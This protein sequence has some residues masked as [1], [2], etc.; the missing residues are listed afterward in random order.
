MC[1]CHVQVPVWEQRS[2]QGDID[3]SVCCIHV[4]AQEF[5]TGLELGTRW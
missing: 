2:V 3:V 1:A 5:N 4:V